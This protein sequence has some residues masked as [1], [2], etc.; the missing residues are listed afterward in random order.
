MEDEV[1]PVSQE[2]LEAAKQQALIAIVEQNDA[3]QKKTPWY[4]KA[5]KWF[6]TVI[7]KPVCQIIF[8]GVKE[9]VSFIINNAENQHLA[10]IAIITAA[11]AGLK[12]NSAWAAAMAV[13]KAGTICVAV[14]K[15]VKCSEIDANIRETLLQLVYTCLKN[16]AL[17]KELLSVK[18]AE[19]SKAVLPELPQ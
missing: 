4:V 12:G 18:P 1:L 10:K 8:S 5:A 19:S 15:Y 16:S 7:I 6:C 2:Q 3:E 9:T 11:K 13:F 14:G 17:G